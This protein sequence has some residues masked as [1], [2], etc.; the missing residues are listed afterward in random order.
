[1]GLKS[2]SL[3]FKNVVKNCLHCNIEF[4]SLKKTNRKFCSTSCSSS[5]N[6]VTRNISEPH[7]LKLKEILNNVR[8]NG[9]AK[10]YCFNRNIRQCLNCENEFYYKT[11]K[12]YCTKCT[13][14]HYK[15][16]RPLCDFKFNLNEF[17][18]KIKGF[19]LLE[20]YGL[21]SP[22]NKK[23]NLNGVSRDHMLSVSWGFKN[24]I[25]PE[26]IRHPANCEL[27]LHSNN[28][29]KNNKNSITYEELLHRIEN[30]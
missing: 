27:L 29:K 7:R 6:N 25:P 30:W 10:L 26:I 15:V 24:N 28:N 17:K 23:N 5:Y 1:M 8:P 13:Y 21:Y 20:E 19:E 9:K 22:T 16:Y 18:D 2:K 11:F 3:E 12:K 4:N 14:D